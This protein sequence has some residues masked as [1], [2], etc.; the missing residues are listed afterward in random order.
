M[1]EGRDACNAVNRVRNRQTQAVFALQGKVPNCARRG[2]LQKTLRNTHV[3][4]FLQ[5]AQVSAD[6]MAYCRLLLLC[7][8]DADGLHARALLILFLVTYCPGLLDTHRIQVVHP[9][10][11]QCTAVATGDTQYAL[12]VQQ[13]QK[14]EAQLQSA[15]GGE[16]STSYYKGIASLPAPVL[17][18]TC[19]NAE[20]RTVSKLSASDGAAVVASLGGLSVNKPSHLKNTRS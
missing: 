20:S 10:L 3:N 15:S 14:V 11:Y 16:V 7:D 9:P 1:V 18:E 2:G 13:M 19:V 4:E 17:A 8:A 5:L 12:S 6:D